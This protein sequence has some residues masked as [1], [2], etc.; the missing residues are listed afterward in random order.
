ML[1][2]VGLRLPCNPV[3]H[4]AGM[5]PACHGHYGLSAPGNPLFSGSHGVGVHAIQHFGA[6]RC[7]A[8]SSAEHAP[9]PRQRVRRVHCAETTA[10]LL[11]S[12]LLD[13]AAASC[14]VYD[15]PR[16]TCRVTKWRGLRRNQL[17]GLRRT[18]PRSRHPCV[19]RPIAPGATPSPHCYSLSRPAPRTPPTSR[20]SQ[21]RASK[22][23]K[24][25]LSR[26]S[27][28]ARQIRSTT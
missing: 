19:R 10:T 14:C 4:R 9:Q 2:T 15:S 16:S 5:Q 26:P 12:D 20:T 21:Q 3:R 23:R 27:R 25:S 8:R 11:A 1:I 6:R 7:S 17:P 22:P 18:Q 13:L 28:C 24:S